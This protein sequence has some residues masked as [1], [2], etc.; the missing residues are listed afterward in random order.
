MTS[1]SRQSS[2]AGRLARLGFVDPARAERLLADPALAGLLDPL[3]DIFEDGVLSAL[4]EVADP[5]L[6]LI[7][8]VRVLDGLRARAGSPAGSRGPISASSVAGLLAMLRAGGAARG[9]LLAVL[10]GSTALADHLTRHPEHW[11]ALEGELGPDEPGVVRADLLAAVAADPDAA[12]PVAGLAVAVAVDALRVAYRRRLLAIAG[13]DLTADDPAAELPAVAGELADL[14]AGALEAALAIARAELSETDPAAVQGCRIAVIG[15]GKC[16]GRELNY[17][18]D[19]DVI[20]VVE[21]A[22]PVESEESGTVVDDASREGAALAAGARL[23]AGVARACSATTAEGSLWEVDA[24]LRPEGRHG[25]LVRTLSSHLAYY[26]RWAHTWEFQALLKARPV[27]GDLALGQAY[28][29]ALGPLV[30]RAAE[31]PNFVQDV[32]AMRR[33]VEQNVPAKNAG[34]QLKL[35]PGGLRDVEFSVQ[36]LQLVHGRGDPRLRTGNTLAGLEALSTYGYV[37]RDDAAELDR[38]YRMLRTLEHRIQLHRLRRTHVVPTAEADLRRIGRSFGFRKDPSAELTELWRRHGRAVRRLHEKL[39]YRPLLAAAARLTTDE[40][41]LTP[42]AAHARLLALGYHDPEG[43]MRHLAA[44]TSGV[45]RRAAI[46]RQL[47]AVMLGWF[48][49]AADPDAGLLSFRRVS[50]GL[51]TTHWY[52]KMLRDSGAAAE[53]LARVLAASRLVAELLERAPEAVAMLGDSAELV[54][55]P[56][57]AL[58][59]SALRSAGRHDNPE[60]AAMAARSVRRREIVRTAIADLVGLLDLDGVGAALS[61]AAIAALDGALAAASSSIAARYGGT[62][63]TRLLVVGMGRLGGSELGY[64][65]DA[66]VLFVHDPHPGADE[67]QAQQAATQVVS[68]LRRLLVLAGPEPR[69]EVDA[70]LRPEGRN[71]PLIRSLDSY[72]QYYRRWSSPWEAQALT[73]AAPA[74]GDRDL[75]ERFVALVDPLRWPSGGIDEAAIREIRRIKARVESERLP[76][77]ADPLRHLKL[78]RGGLADVEWTVQL[79][80]LRY[81]HQLPGLRTTS[82]LG[83]LAA[84]A[85]AGLLDAS[86]HEVLAAA[87]RLASRLRNATVLWRGRPADALPVKM[88]DLDGVAR[89]VGYPPASA[90]VLDDEYQR[91][92]RRARA[93]V[94]RVFYG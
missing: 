5:D 92:T 85:E 23:A 58:L 15:M 83:G 53:R 86:D 79:F 49:D 3:E 94:E 67:Q 42:Q 56:P 30:W 34:R 38:A 63:P 25:P 71:G 48:A 72:A 50:E 9:R 77:G 51:G 4:A 61:A 39:F 22:Q 69:L 70:G 75:A 7:G 13:R 66:D 46:Q 36:L 40:A 76:R 68:E 28:L 84:A 8:L 26:Q 45:S 90:S 82:T 18:S 32:Q 11:T 29:D 93:V 44:L 12:A 16:G 33:R 59:E 35:G 74:A 31:R 55:R 73:R 87:W 65:S 54:P 14:A 52:L 1:M 41:R 17:I 91:T 43:A 27:A 81:A 80:Q 62:L 37:G 20:Y 6:A 2:L 10:A 21:P 64:G 57:A 24:G 78:G 60:T 89:I 88:R 47:L 19:V